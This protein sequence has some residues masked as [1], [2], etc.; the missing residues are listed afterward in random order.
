MI[1]DIWILSVL[2]RIPINFLFLK[3]C[4]QYNIYVNI[5]R[6]LHRTAVPLHSVLFKY[7]Q[8]TCHSNDRYTANI[9]QVVV[10]NYHIFSNNTGKH[11]IFAINQHKYKWHSIDDFTTAI[12]F[13]VL[14][15]AGTSRCWFLCLL[16]TFCSATTKFYTVP[17]D[18][19]IVFV[20]NNYIKFAVLTTF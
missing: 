11:C 17:L 2:Y 10:K 15:T 7:L 19:R 20:F 4:F 5:Y 6:R 18:P 8:Y 12:L 9:Y 13:I 14:S 16:R 3:H 1:H